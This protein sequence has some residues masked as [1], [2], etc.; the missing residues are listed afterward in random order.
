MV[1]IF[2]SVVIDQLISALFLIFGDYDPTVS[3]LKTAAMASQ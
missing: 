3:G 1:E 2:A